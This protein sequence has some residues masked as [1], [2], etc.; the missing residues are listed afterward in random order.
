MHPQRL[1]IIA[2][3]RDDAGVLVAQVCRF[4]Q[5]C[6]DEDPSPWCQTSPG[7]LSA[8]CSAASPST[9]RSKPLVFSRFA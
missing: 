5:T 9:N 6:K 4:G 3:S 2:E 1:V 8:L 7:A